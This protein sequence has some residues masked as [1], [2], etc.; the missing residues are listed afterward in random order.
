MAAAEGERKKRKRKRQPRYPKGW[1]AALRGVVWAL[2]A[3][4]CAWS[5]LGAQSPSWPVCD[6][7]LDTDS[8]VRLQPAQPNPP[9]K[10]LRQC[11]AA[12]TFF[13]IK[14][15]VHLCPTAA[16]T[17]STPAHLLSINTIITANVCL[18]LQL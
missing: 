11:K 9:S 7:V 10:T 13:L 14:P 6:F 16:S 17:P 5:V 2:A 15:T 12:V 18:P 8:Q 1:V 4:V 3:V